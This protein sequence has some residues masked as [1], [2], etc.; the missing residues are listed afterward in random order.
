[1]QINRHIIISVIGISA[2]GAL[3][4]IGQK[5][6]VT[7]VLVG[8]Y[9]FGMMLSLA[10]LIGGT[11]STIAGMIAYLALFYMIISNIGVFQAFGSI[12]GNTANAVS[13]VK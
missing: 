2:I 7:V 12:I 8:A 3:K 6:S 1:M 11:V 5:S 10:D 9:A 4:A 13:Q